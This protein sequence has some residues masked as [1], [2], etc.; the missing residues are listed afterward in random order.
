MAAKALDKKRL[1]AELERER[2]RKVDARLRELRAAIKAA[3]AARREAIALVRTQCRAARVKLRANCKRRAVRAQEEGAA[4]IVAGVGELERERRD[5]KQLRDADR[6]GMKRSGV[7]STRTERRQESDDEVRRNIPDGLVAVFDRVRRH[8][9][10]SDRKSRTE[11]FLEWVEENPGE[12]YALQA[13]DAE[14]ELAKMIA[15][16]ERTERLARKR[17]GRRGSVALADVPF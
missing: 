12:V 16:H 7:R 1:I 14:R 13:V 10:G 17:G 8:I 9:R 11:A 4:R 6:R 5:E 15:E 2:R 3:R